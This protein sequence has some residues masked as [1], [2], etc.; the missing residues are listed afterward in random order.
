MRNFPLLQQQQRYSRVAS[1]AATTQSKIPIP[2]RTRRRRRRDTASTE[3]QQQ[4]RR[5]LQQLDDRTLDTPSTRTRLVFDPFFVIL[6]PYCQPL[7]QTQIN[8]LF[9]A[10]QDALFDEITIHVATIGNALMFDYVLITA[11]NATVHDLD[12]T[13]NVTVGNGVVVLD[14]PNNNAPTRQQV[15][16]WTLDAIRNQ[17]VVPSG[18]LSETIT[19]VS[20]ASASTGNTDQ[21]GG[22]ADGGGSPPENNTT[23]GNTT[24]GTNNPPPNPNGVKDNDSDNGDSIQANGDSDRAKV[25][26]MASIGAAVVSLFSLTALL[27]L[28]A[29]NKLLPYLE[30]SSSSGMDTATRRVG[31]D[32][33]IGR[34]ADLSSK[35]SNFGSSNSSSSSSSN[36]SKNE[37]G[38]YYGTTTTTGEYDDDEEA[39]DG[40]HNISPVLSSASTAS[41]KK[42][43]QQQQQ[44]QISNNNH[45][46]QSY[47]SQRQSQSNHH[48]TAWDNGSYDNRSYADGSESSFTVATEAGD[49]MALKSI[50][51]NDNS[52]GVFG[53]PSGNSSGSGGSFWPTGSD[54]SFFEQTP[55]PPPP[56]SEFSEEQILQQGVLLSSPES[57]EYDRPVNLRKDMLT[58][59]WSGRMPSSAHE[60][61]IRNDSVLQPSYFS[62]SQE[63]RRRR[64][65]DFGGSTASNSNSSRDSQ[66]NNNHPHRRSFAEHRQ[67]YSS[68][69]TSQQNGSSQRRHRNTS[70][71]NY[72]G[73]LSPSSAE[74]SSSGAMPASSVSSSMSASSFPSPAASPSS[75]DRASRSSSP[76][77]QRYNAFSTSSQLQ[78][79]QEGEF[80][81]K[82]VGMEDGS[83][84]ILHGPPAIRSSKSAPLVRD[85][86][87]SDDRSH[88]SSSG[89]RPSKS[90]SVTDGGEGEHTGFLFSSA[91]A[92]EEIIMM[93]PR[94]KARQDLV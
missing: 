87:R 94:A 37:M 75:T 2:W 7:T 16:N 31:G 18:I 84:G 71:G 28:R 47:P 19:S 74:S 62:A 93:P 50:P 66:P 12:C 20:V 88:G 9:M 33:C 14:A 6:A 11:I 21:G 13:V 60:D 69:S 76:N 27:I 49:S 30:E 4:S 51:Y 39:T 64:L 40:K 81:M 89:L 56:S 52:A 29:R 34:S 44:Q 77:H 48:R 43:Q 59:A 42:Q 67:Q 26:V 54:G 73:A 17:F 32:A 5:T 83:H 35:P 46:Q 38:G 36:S 22:D 58:S 70:S 8:H 86:T 79:H 61:S 10:L 92:G 63:R 45:Q 91:N 57:F 15:N 78:E 90:D 72:N 68:G 80:E 1:H 3:Q 82:I 25:V 41:S 24:D 85:E 55:P 23:D 53:L 65:E